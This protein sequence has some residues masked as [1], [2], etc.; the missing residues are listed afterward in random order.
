LEPVKTKTRSV[1]N[2]NT[3]VAEEAAEDVEVVVVAPEVV[4][5]PASN[6]EKRVISQEIA[7]RN[8]H[9]VA[10][11]E[12]VVVAREEVLRPDPELV[13]NVEKKVTML[14][15][16]LRRRKE[17]EATPVAVEEAAVLS[18][19]KDLELA[20]SVEKKDITSVT[21]HLSRLLSTMAVVGVLSVDPNLELVMSAEKKDI[22]FAT[23]LR[24]KDTA[25]VTTPASSALPATR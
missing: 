6:V 16:A 15:T 23:V 4:A 10:Y 20:M 2:S 19:V 14:V 24:K 13:T 7:P 5:V 11:L 18:E 25:V 12:E 22:S 1:N 9:L 8:S 3:V 17:K 21:V